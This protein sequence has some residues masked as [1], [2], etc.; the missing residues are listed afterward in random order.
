MRDEFEIISHNN[1]NYHVFLVNLLYRTPH[2]HKDYEICLLLDGTISVITNDHSFFLQK[3]DIFIINPFQSHEIKAENPALILSLQVSSSFFHS[4]YPQIETV[5]FCHT[6]LY[7]HSSADI[8]YKIRS[9]LL[10]IAGAY[11]QTE[12]LHELKCAALINELFFYILRT[13]DYNLISEKERLT[14]RKRGLRMRKIMDYIDAHYSEKLLLTDIAAQEKLDLYYLSHFFKD[15]FGVSF[16]NYILKVRCEHARQLLILSD[17]S[18]LDISMSCGFSDPKYFNKGFQ[19]L[20]GCT[21]KEYRAQFHT[22]ALPQ[23]QKSLLTTQEF[24]SP[25]ASLITLEKYLCCDPFCDTPQ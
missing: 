23:Q 1:V 3:N 13:Q 15:C 18:L 22:E 20:F 7:N 21:P 16:Q 10:N 9:Y 5:V 2:L 6:C 12:A 4:Y 24:L 11:F 17:Y 14:S 8:C 19:T 25:A